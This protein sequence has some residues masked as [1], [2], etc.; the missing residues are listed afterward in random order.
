MSE[1]PKPADSQDEEGAPLYPQRP[2]RR[3]WGRRLLIV[4]VVMPFVA[5]VLLLSARTYFR[6]TGQRALNAEMARLDAEDPGWRFDDLMAAREKAAPAPGENSA[7]IVRMVRELMPAEWHE[8]TKTQ[9]AQVDAGP[10]PLNVR[11]PFA[12]LTRDADLA[13]STRAAR[14]L[15]LTLRNHPRGHHVIVVGDRP[16]VESLEETQGTRVV[17]H[18]MKTDAL[19]AAQ[20]GD[21]VRGLR[22]AHAILN[23]GRSIGD[24]PTLISTLVHFACDSITTE[25][26]MR[27]LALN[28]ATGSLTEL[29]ALQT[30]LYVELNEPVLLNGLRGERAVVN[31]FFEG[32]NTGR[33]TADTVAG[34]GDMKPGPEVQSNLYFTRTFLP[35]DQRRF[36]TVMSEAIAVATGPYQDRITRTQQIEA[37]F[38]ANRDIRY[39]WHGLMVPAISKLLEADTRCRAELLSA[40]TLIACER[41]RLTRG[42]WPQSLAELPKD[43]LPTIPT[44]P[45]TGEPMR[46]AKLPDGIT[47]YAA[48]PKG[49][50]GLDRKRLTNP[51]GGTEVGWRLY[52]P[53]SR[54]RP[55]LPKEKPDAPGPNG[56]P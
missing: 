2:R 4:F 43:L 37:D 18:L 52:D 28:D 56:M 12:D 10:L 42:R 54:N 20:S 6:H 1:S 45:Y 53:A 22:A 40:A 19:L 33:V 14:D 8:W 16:F 25:V 46:F 15:G 11:Q 24:E 7:A 48:A 47:V 32:I 41:F 5:L 3:Y 51:L 49:I 21:A 35:E 17:A 50:S 27:V 13:A 34:M 23:A 30:A 36:L 26:A 39:P 44:D 38:R 9:S 31:H 29:A 55:P